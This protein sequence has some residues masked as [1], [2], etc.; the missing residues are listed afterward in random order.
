MTGGIQISKKNFFYSF[1]I[2]IMPYC[3]S[4]IRYDLLWA[5]HPPPP[6]HFK[7]PINLEFA[8]GVLHW[9]KNK[10]LWVARGHIRKM[11]KMLDTIGLE[12][13]ECLFVPSFHINFIQNNAFIH[14]YPAMWD[15]K[16][17]LKY[18]QR[19]QY[20]NCWNYAICIAYKIAQYQSIC[21]KRHKWC[22]S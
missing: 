10:T 11:A 16:R 19:H 7:V 8:L 18:F 17:D 14:L 5:T 15:P 12:S 20:N 9:I 13:R 4:W 3:K 1:I 6:F 22:L 21:W 2:H